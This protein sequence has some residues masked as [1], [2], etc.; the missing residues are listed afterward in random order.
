MNPFDFYQDVY[1]QRQIQHKIC[2][3]NIQKQ[4]EQVPDM[5]CIFKCESQETCKFQT[6][7]EDQLYRY[8]FQDDE[9]K[10]L[11]SSRPPSISQIEGQS[12]IASSFSVRMSWRTESMDRQSVDRFTA[13]NQ[14]LERQSSLI[15]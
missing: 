4:C 6:I 15:K 11:I 13:I 14:L 3:N 10:M 7:Y 2:V 12:S 9:F 8:Q 1:E 5:C